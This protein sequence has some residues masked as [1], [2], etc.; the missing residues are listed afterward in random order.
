MK[1]REPA[2]KGLPPQAVS[3]SAAFITGK[4][5]VNYRLAASQP[6]LPPYGPLSCCFLIISD[7]CKTNPSSEA[8]VVV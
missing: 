5:V 6:K 2:R 1:P 3:Q 4:G 8:V 7:S